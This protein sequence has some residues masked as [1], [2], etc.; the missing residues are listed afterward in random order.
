MQAKVTSWHISD[1][2]CRR[3][4]YI[5]QLSSHSPSQPKKQFFSGTASTVTVA[6][7]KKSVNR[8]WVPS[9]ETPGRP[10]NRRP[11]PSGLEVKTRQGNRQWLSAAL[12]K[13]KR[14]TVTRNISSGR[15][16]QQ[17]GRGHQQSGRRLKKRREVS[18][19]GNCYVMSQNGKS[20]KRLSTTSKL[21]RK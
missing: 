12:M 5:K 20:L 14:Q 1:S 18:I 9:V 13:E 4:H 16:H 10:R 21:M 19:K 2:S 15:G 6:T 8:V 11:S 3:L 7:K 17:S